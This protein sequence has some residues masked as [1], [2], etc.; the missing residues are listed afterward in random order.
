MADSHISGWQTKSI[1][2]KRR[3]LAAGWSAHGQ[4]LHQLPLATQLSDGEKTESVHSRAEQ[5]EWRSSVHPG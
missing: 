5:G 1:E 3:R 4:S 2:S